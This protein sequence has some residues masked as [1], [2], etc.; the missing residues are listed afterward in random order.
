MNTLPEDIQD[1]IYKYK[2]QL[3]FKNVVEEFHWLWFEELT[4]LKEYHETRD[5]IIR[6]GLGAGMSYAEAVYNF[7]EYWASIEKYF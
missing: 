6:H 4:K 1:T 2:H 7:E 3:E 5:R